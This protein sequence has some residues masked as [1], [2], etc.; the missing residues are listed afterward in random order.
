MKL[1]T[2]LLACLL[3]SCITTPNK[4]DPIIPAGMTRFDGTYKSSSALLK[5]KHPDWSVTFF[6]ETPELFISGAISLSR[7]D[8]SIDIIKGGPNGERVCRYQSILEMT[9][10][11][12]HKVLANGE[13]MKADTAD[14]V[15]KGF[16]RSR[17][18]LSSLIYLDSL[19]IDGVIRPD[20]ELG[21]PINWITGS[22]NLVP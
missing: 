2:L 9:A 22:F 21:A 3:S 18:Y 10:T 6:T 19:K 1:I 12:F 5:I 4:P 15:Q 8:S 14:L 20:E 11:T 16:S 13:I 17:N 7:P